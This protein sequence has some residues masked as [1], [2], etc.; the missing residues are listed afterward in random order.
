MS[1]P[2]QSQRMQRAV[3]KRRERTPQRSA[4]RSSNYHLSYFF[5]IRNLMAEHE[6][7]RNKA[8]PGQNSALPSR[9][10]PLSAQHHLIQVSKD[11]SVAAN[12]STSVAHMPFHLPR[13]RRVAR[14]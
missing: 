11:S 3:R 14:L 12:D 8:L 4:R 13:H 5:W 10:P 2:V 7:V 9:E 6:I 1:S